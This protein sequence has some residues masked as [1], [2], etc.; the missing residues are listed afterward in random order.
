MSSARRHAPAGLRSACRARILA[1][2]AGT[3]R[4][5]E[6]YPGWH[7]G[8]SIPG[9]AEAGLLFS[10]TSY[11][12]GAA[13]WHSTA[14]VYSHLRDRAGGV[15]P[16][17]PRP[18]RLPSG[19]RTLVDVRLTR[20]LV[21]IVWSRSFCFCRKNG[22]TLSRRLLCSF[23]FATARGGRSLFTRDEKSWL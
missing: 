3:R 12:H 21:C 20:R 4:R 8:I 19:R 5:S 17:K 14:V 11:H 2:A 10:V 16:V 15:Y 6:F 13:V 9:T 23:T 1:H 18:C 7:T 22:L